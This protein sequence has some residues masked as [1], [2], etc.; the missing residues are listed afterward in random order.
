[1]G[2]IIQLSRI[3]YSLCIIAMGIQQLAYGQIGGDFLPGVDSPG[4]VYHLFAYAWGVLFTLSGVAMLIN[5]KARQVALISGAVFLVLLVLV[6]CPYYLFFSPDG[7]SLLG[8]SAAIEE[9]AFV[10]S[11]FIMAS[12]YPADTD[13][14]GLIRWLGRLALYGRIFFGIMLVCY[15]MDHFVVTKF[16]SE[17]IPGWIP[18]HYFWTYFAG[19]ALIGTGVAFILNI[20][21]RLVASLFGIMIFLWFILLHIPTAMQYPTR[22]GGLE[23]SR[24]FVSFGFAGI[25]FLVAASARPGAIPQPA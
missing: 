20:K 18:S 7:H 2:T 22:N 4:L 23:L 3:A 1:M 25:A 6:Y 24:V 8:W 14:S 11:S 15:G 10:G 19:V 5:W 9:S 13:H 21:L 17:M 12:S 16:V